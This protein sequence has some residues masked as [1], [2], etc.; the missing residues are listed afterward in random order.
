[1][2][3]W[4]SLKLGKIKGT[5]Y[6]HIGWVLRSGNTA[7]VH[8]STPLVEKVTMGGVVDSRTPSW[9]LGTYAKTAMIPT[10]GD[11]LPKAK[12]LPAFGEKAHA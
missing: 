8:N 1:M 6:G 5:N 11:R 7:Y 4:K 10:R 2:P 9:C 3:F 12:N